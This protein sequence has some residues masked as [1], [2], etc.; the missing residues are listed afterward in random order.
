MNNL[1]NVSVIVPCRNE[2]KHII[3]FLKSVLDQ[4]YA[5][6]S[7][8]VLVADGRSNDGTRELLASFASAHPQVRVIENP[9]QTTPFA[10]NH[11]IRSST[12]EVIIRMDVHTTYANDYIRRCVETLEKKRADNVGG[13]ARTIANGYMQTAIQLAYHSSFSVGGA[14]FHKVEYEG[15]VDTVT[16][17]CWRKD[18]FTKIGLFDEELTRN[19][20]DELNLRI[21]RAGGKIWQSPLIR[22]WYHPRNSLS[23][24]FQQYQQYGYWKV[25]VIQKHCLPA[26]YRHLVP[27]GFVGI[28]LLLTIL[29]PFYSF[30]GCLSVLIMLFYGGAVFFASLLTCRRANYWKYL[31]VMPFI[32]FAYHLGYGFGFL[33]GVLD[34]VLL[35]RGGRAS[36]KKLTRSG[37]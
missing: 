21:I 37:W 20:D 35:R 8:E 6:G 16:Y 17:G 27:G 36:F 31:P 23:A 34:F 30:A 9:E 15:Y 2:R 1:Y 13:P 5:A 24:L 33:Y 22:S 11:A 14:K 28:L 7:F 19:Q 29:S 12:G 10:L 32:F 3:E 25:R 18:L 26:S 4:D